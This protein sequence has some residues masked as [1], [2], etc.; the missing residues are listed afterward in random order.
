MEQTDILDVESD[1]HLFCLHVFLRQIN[2]PLAEFMAMFN[3]HKLLTA[4]TMPPN[5]IW[6]L[7]MNDTGNHLIHGNIDEPANL[8]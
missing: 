5:Q 8:S 2:F 3:N 7:D 1:I 4:H 6:T